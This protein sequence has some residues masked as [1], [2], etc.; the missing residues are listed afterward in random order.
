MLSR[1][2]LLVLVVAVTACDKVP[3][4]APSSSTITV[5]TAAG[6]VG[7]GGSIEISAF[8]AESSGTAVQNGTVVRFTTNLGRLDP[9]EAQTRNGVAV[10]T[11][12][13]GDSSG[14]ATIRA[15]SGGI[16]GSGD[17]PTNSVTVQVG[18][19]SATTV[20]VSAQPATLPAGGG[21]ST[22]VASV[23]DA[24]GNRLRGIPVTFST[25]QGTLSSSSVTTDSAGNA[26]VQLT[27]NRTARV[28]ARTGGSTAVVSAEVTVTVATENAVTLSTPAAVTLGQPVTLTVTPP[29]GGATPPT[30]SINWGDGTI[31]NL[32]ILA[33]ARTIA[34]T[35]ASTGTFTITATATADGQSVSTSTAAQVNPRT[36]F[37]VALTNTTPTTVGTPI[38]FTAAVTGGDTSAVAT[39]YRWQIQGASG[40]TDAD[41][42]T[43]GP[44]MTRTFSDPG[45]RT[46][47]VTVT[48]SDGRTA[49]SRINVN[50]T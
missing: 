39:E 28:T 33:A 4:T 36:P 20:A 49:T 3:L 14:T 35:Y 7:L 29:G 13:A 12:Q 1:F 15:T 27:T 8:V 37:T 30:V 26:S 47:I 2:L 6:T 23:L 11:F 44:Q 5:T 24:S 19:A 50:V 41:F 40:D 32:G 17:N 43:S 42:T 45:V 9:V 38:T 21:T 18:A 46:V 34:H 22:I 16:G 25:D 10:T 48:F 31:E